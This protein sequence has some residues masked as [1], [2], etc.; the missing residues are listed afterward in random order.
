MI[1][2]YLKIAVRKFWK[3]K[4][5]AFIKLFSLAIGIISLF[6]ISVYIHEELSFDTIHAKKSKIV[7]VNSEI[8]SP[9]GSYSL[10]LT[11]IPVGKYLESISPEVTEFVRVNEEYGV[12][13]LRN[14]DKLFSESENI[15][16]ADVNFF[17]STCSIT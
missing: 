16:Y 5:N 4:G 13:A 15:Y 10:G 2:N 8:T 12:R 9:T 7:R 6:Y 17:N 14:G 3:Q 11:A 1:N